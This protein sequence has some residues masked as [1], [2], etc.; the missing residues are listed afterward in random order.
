MDIHNSIMAVHDMFHMCNNSMVSTII[1]EKK[2]SRAC[3]SV[4]APSLSYNN[5]KN[6]GLSLYCLNYSDIRLNYTINFSHWD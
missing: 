3:V 5:N 6:N 2:K 1:Q 4:V